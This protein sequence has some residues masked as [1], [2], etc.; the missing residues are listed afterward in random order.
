[1]K[2]EPVKAAAWKA[3][4]EEAKELILAGSQ[5][6]K[7]VPVN[8][9]FFDYWGN[10]DK[11]LLFYGAYGSGKSIFVA[12]MMIDRCMQPQYAR[13]YFG[14]KILDTVRGTIFQTIV[15][16]IKELNLE[17]HF[18]FSEAP[19]GS[20]HIRCKDNDNKFIPFGANDPQSLKSIKDP[21]HFI[22]EEMD[23]FDWDDFGL[24]LSRLRT[25]K[26]KT[27]L[28]GM[29]NTDR[30]YQSHWIRKML[31]D[32][33]FA[34]M[35]TK[36]KAGFRENVFIDAAEYERS[37][38]LISG[39]NV[40]KFNAIAEGEMAL[41]R[42]GN[43]FWKQFDETKHIGPAPVSKSTIHVSLDEN[44][45]P[46]V[47]VSIWQVDTA[48]KQLR[49]VHEIPC[50]SPDNNAPKAAKKLTD[51]LQGI[52]YT[53]VVFLY[54][55]PSASAKSTIDP[56]NRSFY[57]KFIEVLEKEGYKVTSRVQRSAPEV[58]L[59]AA[60]INAIYEQNLGGW[61]ILIG[62]R[63]FTSIEDYLLVKEDADGRMF[64]EKVKDKETGITAE[65]RGHF[66]D[67]KRYFITTILASEFAAFRSRS[68][69]RGIQDVPG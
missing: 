17:D 3:L 66:S 63:C 26:V 38:R 11:I 62:E 9:V 33:E 27:Q 37:L 56:N 13:I 47:T 49:Q 44:V 36:I 5:N 40:A 45:N 10:Q 42:T 58:A 69:R 23:Q 35:A 15:D 65:P 29:F 51:W 16:R 54:G 41:I 48:A 4:P 22:L 31:F 50:K 21:T 7:A 8:E 30:L 43:E 2:L 19:N 52:G 24:F 12:D 34:S 18:Y 57:D 59:S 1:M 28:I 64:K 6:K 61:S 39:G 67:A 14:R 55:D 20:M 46:Y 32:G 68:R 25:S 53:D 60:F